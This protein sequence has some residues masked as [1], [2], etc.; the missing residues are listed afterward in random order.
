MILGVA[1]WSLYYK[2]LQANVTLVIIIIK[3]IIESCVRFDF[4]FKILHF[5]LKVK[6]LSA[7]YQLVNQ[8][9]KQ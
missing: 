7:S 4:S 8:Y 2:T 1:G 9:I 6:L 5:G 3:I